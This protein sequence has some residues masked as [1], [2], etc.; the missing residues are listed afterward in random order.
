[1]MWYVHCLFQL[2]PFYLSDQADNVHANMDSVSK[3]QITLIVYL[4][5][6]KREATFMR[7]L[8]IFSL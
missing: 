3:R 6:A 8:D 4:H 5:H 7:N 2:F 1:M